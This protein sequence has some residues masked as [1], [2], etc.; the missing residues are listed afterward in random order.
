[1]PSKKEPGNE[2]EQQPPDLF[3]SGETRAMLEEF[4]ELV[5]AGILRVT[6]E[7]EVLPVRQRTGE[8]KLEK[9]AETA[10]SREEEVALL[11]K[12]LLDWFE[13]RRESKGQEAEPARSRP[14]DALAASIRQ[15]VIERVAQK[16]LDTW[17]LADRAADPRDQLREQIVERIAEEILRRMQRNLE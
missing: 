10:A 5:R 3:S 4:R 8:S 12:Q 15:R 16:V 7:N 13:R 14:A 2:P 9:S 1:L 6:P 17:D 11:D